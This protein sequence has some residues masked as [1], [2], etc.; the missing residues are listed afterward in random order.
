[1][2]IEGGRREKEARAPLPRTLP[3]LLSLKV[4]LPFTFEKD[5]RKKI[6]CFLLD[7]TDYCIHAL[8]FWWALSHFS[9]IHIHCTHFSSPLYILLQD[10]IGLK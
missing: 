2:T 4:A 5:D 3:P 1:M 6:S 8:I 9:S 7:V 10:I